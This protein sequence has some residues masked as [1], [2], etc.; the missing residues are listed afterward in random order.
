[1]GNGGSLEEKKNALVA[2]AEWA[3]QKLGGA[4][5][6]DQRGL[7]SCDQWTWENQCGEPSGR[8]ERARD[9]V[10]KTASVEEGKG[11]MKA[12]STVWGLKGW[13]QGKGH[14]HRHSLGP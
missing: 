13:E 9:T 6:Q 1:M 7:A 8:Q 11:G 4:A 5:T 14:I 12:G 10:G 2:R 3:N